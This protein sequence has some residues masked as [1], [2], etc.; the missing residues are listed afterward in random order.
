MKSAAITELEKLGISR[1]KN[2][3]RWANLG[4]E[5]SELQISFY[6]LFAGTQLLDLL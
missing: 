2:R 1:E 4:L 3:D 5:V 6:K